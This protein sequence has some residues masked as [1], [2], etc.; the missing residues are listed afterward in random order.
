M[1]EKREANRAWAY[2]FAKPVCVQ[3]R[4]PNPYM[5]CVDSGPEDVTVVEDGVEKVVQFGTA[6]AALTDK[7][8]VVLH[9]MEGHLFEDPCDP[10]ALILHTE[11]SYE[12][13]GGK[14]TV[15]LVIRINPEDIS[16]ITT[17]PERTE[18]SRIVAP[19]TLPKP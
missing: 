19:L 2:W 13:K 12:A 16:F 3:F 17:I 9:A 15:K 1:N 8:P 5:M 7:G 4:A 11:K 14:Q 10:S 6:T 18:A